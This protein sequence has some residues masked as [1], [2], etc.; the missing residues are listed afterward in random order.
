MLAIVSPDEP[1]EFLAKAD[2][3]A[4]SDAALVFSGDVDYVRTREAAR[5]YRARYVRYLVFSGH[6][7]PGDSAQSM[8]QVA[9]QHGVPSRAML[10]E[11]RATS[12]YENVLFV[13]GLL[14]RRH[15]RRLI[16][17]ASWYQQRRAYLVARSLLPGMVLINDPAWAPYWRAHGW[18]RDAVTRQIVLDEYAKLAGYLMLGRL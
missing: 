14:A 5:L 12:T 13:R 10:M 18:W 16:L 6:G 2:R 7:G 4:G 8:A 1:V 17:V 3:L 11:G 9:L 15:V